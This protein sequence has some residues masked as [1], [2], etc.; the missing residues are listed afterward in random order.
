M[1]KKTINQSAMD[2]LMGG[3]VPS[4]ASPE[5]SDRKKSEKPVNVRIC[6][7]IDSELMIKVR[8]LA[9]KEG[10]DL[11]DI[12]NVGLRMA[13]KDYESTHGPIEIKRPKKGD[14]ANVF[15]I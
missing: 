12:F 1:S 7:L 11:K 13:I 8:A 10:L 6:T 4:S 5:S 15:T 3:L 14:V 2:E 9:Q